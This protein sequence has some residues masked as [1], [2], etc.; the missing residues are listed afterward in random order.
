MG[1]LLDS[2]PQVEPVLFGLVDTLSNGIA[3]G[4]PV[5]MD[6]AQNAI[7]PLMDVLGQLG[8]A[9]APV[10]GIM[11]SIGNDGIAAA[12]PNDWKHRYYSGTAAG[13]AS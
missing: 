12:G 6:L 2:W 1:S 10:G 4:A 13:S 9:A 5:I 11:L 7:P 8:T 3:A